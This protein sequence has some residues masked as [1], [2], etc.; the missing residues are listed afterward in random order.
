MENTSQSWANKKHLHPVCS[1]I[2]T[3]CLG[4]IFSFLSL[5]LFLLSSSLFVTPA[6]ASFQESLWGA[7][8]A[9]LVGAF[10]ALADDANA[11]AYNPAGITMM[12]RDE[13]TL[14][15]AQLYSGVNFYAGENDTS[16]LGLGYFS[17]VPT[18]LD[19]EYGSYAVSWTNFS[20]T[21]LYR[22]DALSLTYADS[23]QFENLKRNPILSWGLNLK[24]LRRSFSTDSRT[25][26]DPVFQ[27]GRDSDA[28]TFD[29]GLMFRPYF[30]ILPGL[31]FGAAAQN[32]TEPDMGLASSD[33]VPARYSLGVAYQDRGLRWLNPAIEVQRRRGR[34]VV[35]A[36]WESWVARDA[37]A[38]RVGGNEDRLGAGM[39]YQFKI[40][41]G[42]ILRLDYA[43]IWPLNVEG[44]NGSHRVSITT[45]F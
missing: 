27:S 33:R 38:I 41:K 13:L 7:R 1:V 18:V 2:N 42:L 14:M 40:F 37:L 26:V 31:K 19:K 16:R 9:A 20:A 3:G 34:T 36:A 12:T 39:G 23:Y 35:S 28:L 5:L 24:A 15:Y 11:P 44:T 10:T 21:N 4:K 30:D 43:L 45:N 25:D 8:P 29:V 22:E 6:F 17:Y 32:V